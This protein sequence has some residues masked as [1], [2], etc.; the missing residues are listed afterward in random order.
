MCIEPYLPISFICVH[1]YVNK[2]MKRCGV[3][4]YFGIQ[5]KKDGKDQETIQLS[6][7]PDPGYHM[8]KYMLQRTIVKRP[9]LSQ[10]LT[11]KQQ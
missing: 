1:L 4:I 10:Q 8:G 3:L 7:T 6:T 2:N 11:T 5:S 9:A